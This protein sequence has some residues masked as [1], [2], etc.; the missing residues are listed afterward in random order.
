MVQITF[1]DSKG[2]PIKEEKSQ[3]KWIPYYEYLLHQYMFGRLEDGPEK[4]L[5]REYSNYAFPLVRVGKETIS[6][7]EFV[8]QKQTN[9]QTETK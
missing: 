6:L 1:L 3:P 5:C 4:N 8:K 9:V 2:N 7:E